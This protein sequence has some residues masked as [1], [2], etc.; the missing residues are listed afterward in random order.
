MYGYNGLTGTA[1]NLFFNRAGEVLYF[2]AA[3]CVCYNREAHTQRFFT[4]HD[5]DVLCLNISSD[6]LLAVSGQ[7]GAA[8]AVHVWSTDGLELQASLAHERGSRGVV[9][10]AFSP[11]ARFV[12]SVASDNNHTVH[13]WDWRRRALLAAVPGFNGTPPQVTAHA[14]AV[15]GSC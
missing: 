13:V 7:I 10:V 2:V 1:N 6:R 3:L 5:D 15:G 11:D 9:A 12:L 14:A 8:P 4:A